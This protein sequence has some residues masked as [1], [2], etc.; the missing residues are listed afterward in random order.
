MKSTCVCDGRCD[1]EIGKVRGFYAFYLANLGT[2]A[3]SIERRVNS[4]SW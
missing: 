1:L 2:Q 4:G 3:R